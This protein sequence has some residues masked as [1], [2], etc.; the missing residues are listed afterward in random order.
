MIFAGRCRRGRIIAKTS[1]RKRSIGLKLIVVARHLRQS[2]DQSVER[3]GL[4]RAKWTLIAAVARN[5]GA[6]Q[7][8]IAEALEIREV[9]AGR[10][11]DRLCAAGYLKRREHPSDGRAYCVHLAPGAQPI[12]DTLGEL[13]RQHEGAIFAGF[14]GDDLDR[15]EALLDRISHN[16]SA[17]RPRHEAKK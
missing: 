4:T 11:I 3:S 1:N 7:R 8:M 2:F 6:T 10:L 16:L 14:D 15:L 17:A 13:A 5:P 12:L 9:T